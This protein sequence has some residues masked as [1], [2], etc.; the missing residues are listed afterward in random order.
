MEFME[1]SHQTCM[2]WIPGR[3]GEAPMPGSGNHGPTRGLDDK[4]NG[5]T[6]CDPAVD[7]PDRFESFLLGENEQ[8]VEVEPETREY[9]Q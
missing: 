2:S 4:R 3:G 5:G 6:K 9:C 8:K 1:A 7:I